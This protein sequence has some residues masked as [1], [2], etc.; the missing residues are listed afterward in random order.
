MK[1]YLGHLASHHATQRVNVINPLPL[2]F[3]IENWI[4]TMF[5]TMV[6]KRTS[7]EYIQL[8]VLENLSQYL[9]NNK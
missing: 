7:M 9:L 4:P 5:R 3:V 6:R 8:S 2:K 1:K